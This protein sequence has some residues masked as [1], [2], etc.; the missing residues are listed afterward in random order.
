MGGLAITIPGAAFSR[1]IDTAIPWLSLANGYYLFGTD[2]ATSKRNYAVGA[3]VDLTSNGAPTYGPGYVAL[4]ATTDYYDTGIPLTGDQTILVASQMPTNTEELF[5]PSAGIGLSMRG[6]GVGSVR[7]DCA[8]GGG[9]PLVAHQIGVDYMLNGGTTSGVNGSA[10]KGYTSTGGVVTET[11]GAGALAGTLGTATTMR[12]GPSLAVSGGTGYRMAAAMTFD[13]QLT[14]A[15][16]TDI[17]NYWRYA[18]PKRG[19]ISIS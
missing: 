18:L 14:L 4:A 9:T 19:A 3:S 6:A 13:T 17:F 5:T 10:I 15:Q 12:L 7:L 1:F 11:V 2:F 16:I 8:L